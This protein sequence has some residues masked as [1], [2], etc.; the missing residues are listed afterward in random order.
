MLNELQK[1]FEFTILLY[2]KALGFKILRNFCIEIF[3]EGFQI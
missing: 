2:R 1:C 3:L